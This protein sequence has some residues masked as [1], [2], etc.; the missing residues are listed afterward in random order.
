MN[1]NLK[2][3]RKDRQERDCPHCCIDIDFEFEECPNNDAYI[4]PI[5]RRINLTEQRL[6]EKHRKEKEDIYNC[7][8]HNKPRLGYC[9]DCQEEANQNIRK[10]LEEFRVHLC[11]PYGFDKHFAEFLT[12]KNTGIPGKKEKE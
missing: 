2:V 1:D 9:E 5:K 10:K 4:C 7:P 11:Y 8:V 12:D 6:K 3:T